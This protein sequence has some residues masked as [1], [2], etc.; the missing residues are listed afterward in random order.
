MAEISANLIKE[1]REK[2]GAGVL[3]CKKA[4][5][6]S[7]GDLS[8]AI[9]G[10]RKSGAAKAEKKTGRIT[11]EGRVLAKQQGDRAVLLEV[12]CETDFVAK[13]EDFQAFVENLA[14]LILKENPSGA[15]ALLQAS[16]KGQAVKE[17]LQTLIAKIGE[18]ISIRRFA[19]MQVQAGEKI[20]SYI[21]MG[22]KIGV[23][24][25]IK[26]SVSKLEE[27]VLR[28]V[29]MHV[30]ASAP[31]YLVRQEIPQDVLER[32]KSIYLEQMKELKKPPAVLEKI[33]EGKIARFADEVCLVDQP[34]VKDPTGKQ[35]L[36]A[37]LKEKDPSLQVT[38][39]LRYQ[40]GEGIAKK[41]EDFASEVAKSLQGH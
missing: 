40:V 34:F 20:G 23:L 22:N 24:V 19:V 25:K 31:Q 38:Q 5:V 13:N 18:N 26:G 27:P 28:D 17:V 39:F 9:E 14:E 41:E 16:L 35:T 1:L 21:H 11:A 29:A 37:Y 2:T 36:A 15:E 33:L 7:Q 8:K 6:E 4:L 3:D 10:L 30:A 32:E 12:N